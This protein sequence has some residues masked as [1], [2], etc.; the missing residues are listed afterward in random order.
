MHE[1]NVLIGAFV[2][3]EK[4]QDG[5][6]KDAV[7]DILIHAAATPDAKGACWYPT[8][9][10]VN[11]AYTG[12]PEGSPIRRL[13]AD[14]YVFHSRRRWLDGQKNVDLLA[15][16][17]GYLLGDRSE[18][19]QALNSTT[20]DASGCQYHY[21]HGKKSVCYVAKILNHMS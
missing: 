20:P 17:A 9:R 18:H 5:D 13:L 2:F 14:M 21:H 8:G 10:L 19:T 4:V 7:I 16:L 3:G 12:T 6:F 1:L 11:L 15:D